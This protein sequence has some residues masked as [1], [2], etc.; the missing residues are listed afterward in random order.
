M[1]KVM[2]IEVKELVKLQ[3]A[4]EGIV[5]DLHGRPVLVAIQQITL[6]AMG[7]AREYAPWDTG[8]LRASIVPEVRLMGGREV[9][10]IVGTNVVYAPYQEFGWTTKSGTKVA[11]RHYFQRALDYVMKTGFV[12]RL[13]GEVVPRIIANRLKQ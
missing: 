5:E 10:G 9:R 4:M 8:R 1:A 3:A 12:N 11:G 6:I 2:T 13:I 7:K